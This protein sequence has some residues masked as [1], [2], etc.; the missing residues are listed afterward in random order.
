[1][2]KRV[3]VDTDLLLDVALARQPILEMSRMVLALLENNIAIGFVSSNCIANIYYILRKAGG[4][5]KARTFISKIMEYLTVISIEH[6]DVVA[7]L[8][9]GFSDFED[10]LQ[11]FSA[12]RNQCGCIVTRNNDDYKNSKIAVYSP[13]DFLS[14][15]IGKH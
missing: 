2:M 1:M 3:F 9:S 7:A 14:L 13:R 15:Y 12:M 5:E 10:G 8:K 6:S 4:D 11:H